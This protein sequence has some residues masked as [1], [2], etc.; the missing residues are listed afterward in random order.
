MTIKLTENQ[1]ITSILYPISLQ[2]PSANNTCIKRL[3]KFNTIVRPF[4]KSQKR[5]KKFVYTKILYL[6]VPDY[7][8]LMSLID[9]FFVKIIGQWATSIIF[10]IIF[11]FIL[12]Q[13]TPQLRMTED[14]V[15]I[16]NSLIEEKKTQN[17]FA[18][19]FNLIAKECNKI[20]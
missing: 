5:E 9:T 2:Y 16:L 8:D 19:V 18:Q 10:Y 3:I 20:L 4:F 14:I 7:T 17:I 13:K 15:S 6:F 12:K 1:E 11:S